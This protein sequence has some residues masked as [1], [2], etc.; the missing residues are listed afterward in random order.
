MHS[1]SESHTHTPAPVDYKATFYRLLRYFKPYRFGVLLA[2]VALAIYGGVDASMVYLVQPLIDEGLAKSDGDVLKFGSVLIL[3]I[4]AVRG[5]ASFVSTYCLSWA[6]NHVIRQMRQQLYQQMLAMPVSFFDQNSSGK[7]ISKL[8]YDT[9]QVA[10]ATSQVMIAL[11]REGITII[12]LLAIMFYQSWQLSLVF[13]IVGPL[14]GV[15]ISIVSKRFRKVSKGIQRAMGEVTTSTEQMLKGHKVVLA[16]SGQEKEA[17]RFDKINNRNRQ[18]AMKLVAAKAVSTPVIQ[19]L[20]SIAIAVVLY[21]AST[22]V[23][24]DLSPGAFTSIV[25][26]MGALMR[27]LKQI[28]KVN[29]DFQRGL[30]ACASVFELLDQPK[31]RDNGTRTAERV[32]GELAISEL[33]F[34]YQGKETPALDN[35]SLDIRA[36]ETVALVGRSGSGK[37]TLSSLL[38]RFYDGS[39]G[40]ITLDGHN[41]EDFQ[42]DSLRKQF[43]LVSQQVVL[44]DDTIAANIAYGCL[45]DASR[46]AIEA[47]ARAAHVMEFAQH[48]PDGLDTRVGEDGANMSG[49]QRQ[50]IAIARAILRDAPILI[51]D[52]ATSALDT[53]SERAIQEALEG[54]QQDRTSIVVAH[55]LSTIE[56]ADKIVVMEQGRIIEQGTHQQLLAKDGAYRQLHRMQFSES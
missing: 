18:Q 53:E 25:G 51:L 11:V 2:I 39:P 26:A 55:R 28:T 9:E 12:A 17:G 5:L 50:R 22:S 29:A 3:G 34:C 56:N 35:I 54:L 33:E 47:A 31:E 41:I 7:L 24:A 16:F 46:E 38:M 27:P 1:H 10:L 32:R 45:S 40:A 42:L 20:G 6:S 52:E 4:F 43:A 8:T 49:G 13:F 19:F 37:S 21:I 30:T 48:L 15:I 14:I 36:G 23:V 44:F